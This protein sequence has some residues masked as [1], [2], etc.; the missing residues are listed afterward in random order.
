MQD[1]VHPNAKASFIATS[2]S[3][4]FGTKDAEVLDTS[5][6]LVLEECQQAQLSREGSY[7][8]ACSEAKVPGAFFSHGSI[9]CCEDQITLS[10]ML[11]VHQLA[12][13]FCP[14]HCRII[15]LYV[16]EDQQ[17]LTEDHI[18]NVGATELETMSG[19]TP[20]GKSLASCMTGP[21]VEHEL[22][23]LDGQDLKALM[24]RAERGW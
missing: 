17:L 24:L 2:T 8:S 15:L 5:V 7:L 12:S 14:K 23:L 6:A 21:T 9:S 1:K 22:D 4:E 10:K 16:Q 11:Q 18:R 20:G 19:T 13:N 3:P